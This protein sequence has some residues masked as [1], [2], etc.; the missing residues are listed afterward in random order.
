V[1]SELL[2]VAGAT[3]LVAVAAMTVSALVAR[4][5]GRV[6]VVD[7]TW[8]LA[9]LAVAVV[10]AVISPTWEAWVLVGLVGV[11]GVRLS[12]HIQSRSRGAGEDPRYAEMLGGGGFGTAVRKVFGI[13]GA[14]VWLVSMPLQ[15][16]AVTDVVWPWVCP[17]GVAVWAVGVAFEVI[18]D[19]QLAAYR[20]RPRDQRPPVLDTGL[21]GWTRHPNYFG[22]ALVWWGI[23]MTGALSA[24]WLPALVTVV[25]PVM[26]T[27]F[28]RNVTGAKLLERSMSGRSGWEE[29]AARVPLFVPRPPRRVTPR[30]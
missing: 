17:V 11:W 12:W 8:G 28:L 16:A 18:G 3:L 27:H 4:R 13:Q 30:D 5:V 19:R 23:W 9:L 21:W 22:D 24:G 15:A 29:Y 20:V 6:N 1:L 2:V 10:C 25:A 7:V 14:A 26:M